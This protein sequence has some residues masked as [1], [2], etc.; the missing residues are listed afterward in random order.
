MAASRI[1]GITIKIGGD[2]TQLQKSLQGVDKVLKTTQNNLKDV[3]RLLKLDPK[4]AELLTQKQKN[5]AGAIDTTKQR[6]KELRSVSKDS[7]KPEEWDAVQREIAETEQDLKKLEKEYKNFGSVGAQQ[8]AAVGKQVE[9]V[10]HKMAEV[11]QTMTTY[12][13]LPLVALG[14]AGAKSFAEVDKTMQLTNATMGNTAEQAE[15]LNNAMKDAAA[16][17]TFGMNDAATATLNFA[18][19]GLTAEEA[20]AAL[21]P[22]MNLAA[23]EGGNLD[24]VSGGLVATINGFGD[25]FDNAAYYADVFANACNNSAL[26]VDELSSAMST[27]APIFAAAGYSVS[28]AALYMGVMANAGIP[29]AEAA[30]ALKTGLARLIKPSKE[31]ATWMKK[32]GVSVTNADGSMKDSVTIQKEL[33]DAFGTLS[34]SEQIA[35]ASAI[36][37]KNQMSNWLALI[38]TAPEDV[39]SLSTAL[40]TEG[41]TAQMAEAMMSGFGGSLEKL[42]SSLDVAMTSLGEALAPVILAVAEKIQ[43]LVDWFNSLDASQQQMIATIGLVVAAIGPILLILGNLIVLVGQVMTFAPLIIG[44]IGPVVAAIGSVVTAIGIIPIAIAAAAILIITHWEQIKA[45][46]AAFVAAAKE[47]FEKFKA[48]VKEVWNNIVTAV[49]NAVDKVKQ[50]IEDMKT[51][52]GDRITAIKNF[53]IGLQTTIG[54]KIEAIKT[55]FGEMKTNIITTATNLLS[56]VKEKFEAVKKAITDPVDTAKELVSKA[57]DAI[58]GFFSGAK[59]EFP[60]I[61]LPHFSWTW[62]SI[63]GLVS[64]PKIHI[65]WYKKAYDNPY[66]F[67]SPTLMGTNAGLKGFGDGNGGEIVYG[68]DQLMRD[69]AQAAGGETNYTVNVYAADGMDINVLATKVQDKFVQWERQKEAAFA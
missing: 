5:L 52:I 53:F 44:A 17:S 59:F 31:G 66:L 62:E 61:N 10:G 24:T 20:A 41:T 64:I 21:A 60:H 15:L 25:T 63:G 7:V 38:N 12:V 26:N 29:A 47:E 50:K 27:A 9:A 18:R 65:D 1:K 16:N 40:Q 2:T 39:N 22:A 55:K 57:I 23:G 8:V 3:N 48:K 34:E 67:T 14:T 19:A 4:N 42:K 11:G 37:G 68:R 58:K 69:I 32:L 46:T 30:N 54:E 28:D 33:H 13:T 45:A 51:A 56:S 43:G 6:L 36:F 49:K 35:A